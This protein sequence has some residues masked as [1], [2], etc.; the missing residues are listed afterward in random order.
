VLRDLGGLRGVG[1]ETAT[2]FFVGVEGS[3]CEARDGGSSVVD[4]VAFP[5]VGSSKGGNGR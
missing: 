4:G 1:G 2:A 5:G 3:C